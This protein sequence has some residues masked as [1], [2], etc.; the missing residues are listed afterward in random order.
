MTTP[1]SPKKLENNQSHHLTPLHITS[2]GSYIT[3][4][5]WRTH[6]PFIQWQHSFHMK[7]GLPLDKR[8]A[9]ES[10]GF[11]KEGLSFPDMASSTAH[12]RLMLLRTDLLRD[13]LVA[14]EW[15]ETGENTMR[16]EKESSATGARGCTSDRAAG[17]VKP[18]PEIWKH[19]HG[20]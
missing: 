12:K 3:D 10:H 5:I 19:K 11:S 14:G 15:L 2:P 9:V 1:L 4:V 18:R 16:L 7:S 6:K 17:G 13:A 8:F 20:I